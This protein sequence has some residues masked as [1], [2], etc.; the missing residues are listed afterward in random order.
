MRSAS[1]RWLA[2]DAGAGHSYPH[3]LVMCWNALTRFGVFLLVSLLISELRGALDHLRELSRTDSLTGAVNFRHFQEL[4]RTEIDRS[5]RYKR[6]FTLAYIDADNFKAVND[7]Y[8]HSVG[9]RL[10]RSVVDGDSTHDEP[11]PQGH[12]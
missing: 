3:V 9:D 2:A 6:T 4:V 11:T 7:I 8:G 10:L 5:E 1:D 12:A